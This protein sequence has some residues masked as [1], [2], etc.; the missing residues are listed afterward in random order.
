MGRYYFHVWDGSNLRWDRDGLEL[1]SLDEAREEIAAAVRML[2]PTGHDLSGHV[3]HVMAEDGSL[4][5]VPLQQVRTA[6]TAVAPSRLSRLLRRGTG[7]V[8]PLRTGT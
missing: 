2:G 6:V 1:D 3:V 7:S 8:R 4:T 5:S